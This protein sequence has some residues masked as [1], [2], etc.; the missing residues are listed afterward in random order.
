MARRGQA[1]THHDP[2]VHANLVNHFVR[3][4]QGEEQSAMTSFGG[5]PLFLLPLWEKVARRAG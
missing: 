3:S 4:S 1:R 2:V 5:K